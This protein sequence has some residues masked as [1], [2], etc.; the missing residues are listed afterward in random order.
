M[1]TRKVL[2]ILA[3][4]VVLF[5]IAAGAT[6]WLA[7][8]PHIEPAPA[9]EPE[10]PGWCPAVEVIS[11]PGTWE[12][13]RD[14]DPVNPQANP[15]SF[16]LTITRPLQEQYDPGHVKVW[17]L[18]YTAQFRNIQTPQAREEMGYDD[19]RNEGMARLNAELT[20][21]AESCPKTEFILS[22]FSQ[23]AVI[24]GDIASDI[25]N[26]RGVVP[27][28]R[29]RGA[30]MIADGRRLNDEGI[31]PGL[32]L[33]GVGAEIALEP[34]NAIVEP[35]VPGATMRGPRDGGF[36]ALNDRAIEICAP[37]DSICDAPQRV[38]DALGRARAMV[39][40]NGVHA[41]YA[42]NPNVIPGTTA[43][44]WAVEWIRE[45]IDS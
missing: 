43:N 12:S 3:V 44:Q 33:N 9:P 2:T 32:P 20:H 37:D 5:A 11:A 27:P 17:T 4:I 10:Q 34:L 28:E 1:R 24:V 38:F 29:V 23:G 26:H 39:E 35:I 36:G 16:M 6:Q 22:G 8:D 19:S 42:S 40:A 15:A 31:N 7:R 45:R 21:M 30:V 41:M 25:G 14:D 13:A 18:P